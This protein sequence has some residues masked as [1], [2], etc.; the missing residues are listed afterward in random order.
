MV[1]VVHY[2]EIGTKGKN[3]PKFERQLMKNIG[4]KLD[5]EV[6]RRYGRIV[7]NSSDNNGLENIPGIA[8]FANAC[9][10]E[11]D[12]EDIK[13]KVLAVVDG[14]EFSS[15]SVRAKRS[16]KNFSLTSKEIEEKIGKIVVDKF[17]KKVDLSNPDLE[18]FIDIGEK[19][20]FVY[21]DK[22]RGIGGLPVGISGKVIVSLS[23]G[24]DS[25]VAS[26]LMMK[27]GCECVY[28][29]F[30]HNG[31]SVEKVKSLVEKLG[32]GKLILVNFRDI[33]NEIIKNVKAE[34]R[35]IVYRRYMMRILGGIALREK[36]KAIVTGDSVGQVA[37]QT[38]ENI[39]LI[40]GVCRE[41]INNCKTGISGADDDRLGSGKSRC[42][43]VLSPL[44]GMN[45]EE[46]IDISKK[47][48]TFDVSIKPGEDCCSFMIA[49]HPSTR[50][51]LSKILKSE[52]GI[53][54]EL[55]E[56]AVEEVDIA[57][58]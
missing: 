54:D 27:R 40:H 44:I 55:V 39:G 16:N 13:E 29:H 57:K 24:I 12:I 48:D 32:S 15:F 2:S 26:W 37:S 33:Q 20:A 8:Y 34:D 30:Y 51:E 56:K 36:C 11:L 9:V 18:I 7:V 4:D 38:L 6:S 42:V 19:E 5:C 47:I 45:K 52:E 58:D 1:I 22:I 35:M 10:A 25:P 43:P 23:G 41:E 50:G 28:V 53:D 46:I 49:E 14:K 17:D 3:R 21:T 31:E